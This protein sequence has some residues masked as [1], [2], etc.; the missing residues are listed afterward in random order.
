VDTPAAGVRTA[1]F[2]ST[3]EEALNLIRDGRLLRRTLDPGRDSAFLTTI[4]RAEVVL[5]ELAAV[6]NDSEGRGVE[7]LQATLRGSKLL[8]QI[9]A[10][11]VEKEVDIALAASGWIGEEL[12]ERKEF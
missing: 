11:N 3:R 10:L 9:A 4:N 6:E 2:A 12:V 5:E 1:D 8:L 7:L